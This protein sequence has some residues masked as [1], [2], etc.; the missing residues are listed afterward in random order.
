LEHTLITIDIQDT[1][2]EPARAVAVKVKWANHEAAVAVPDALQFL[3]RASDVE[4][5]ARRA[6]WLEEPADC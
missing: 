6:A 5:Y 1:N 2:R 4:N 3:L